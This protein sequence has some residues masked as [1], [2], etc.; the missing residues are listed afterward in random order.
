M[1]GDHMSMNRQVSDF[2]TTVQQMRR[3]FRRDSNAMNNYLS[4]CIFYSGLG[5]NDY[6]NNYFMTD[7][8]TTSSQYT[9]RAFAAALL[10]DYSRQ[11]T[12][13]KDPPQ[14]ALIMIYDIIQSCHNVF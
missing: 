4:K 2:A 8:Y 5:S 7:F 10:Q 3:F 14:S 13:R 9:P 1:Q 12:V 6:L 11:L